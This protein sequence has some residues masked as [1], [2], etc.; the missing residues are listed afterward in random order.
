MKEEKKT[1]SLIRPIKQVKFHLLDRIP[2]KN[3]LFWGEK[4]IF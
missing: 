2:K 3:K 4:V 1:C